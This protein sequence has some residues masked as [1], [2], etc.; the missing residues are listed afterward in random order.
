MFWPRTASKL[1]PP[2]KAPA[3]RAPDTS[4]APIGLMSQGFAEVDA[5]TLGLWRTEASG[6]RLYLRI[7]SA[8]AESQHLLFR[9]AHNEI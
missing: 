9:C 7:R 3:L 6:R 4:L 8:G 1:P 2:E 5:A